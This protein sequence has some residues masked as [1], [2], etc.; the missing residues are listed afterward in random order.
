MVD[1]ET[2]QV[3]D[4]PLTLTYTPAVPTARTTIHVEPAGGRRERDRARRDADIVIEGN[5]IR[6]VAPHSAAAHRGAVIDG[7]GL[8]AMPGLIEFHSHLQKDFGEAQGRA[9]LAFGVTTVRSPGQHAV[10]SGRGSRGRRGRRS[11]PGRASTAPA[12]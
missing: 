8:T 3:T 12:T 1:I 6:S 11:G 7:T 9:W 5:R 10:R 2:G 4:V